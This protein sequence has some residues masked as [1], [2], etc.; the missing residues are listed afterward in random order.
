[1]EYSNQRQPELQYGVFM[2]KIVRIGPYSGNERDQAGTQTIFYQSLTDPPN[3]IRHHFIKSLSTFPYEEL[4]V[5]EI[6]TLVSCRWAKTWQF[7]YA[8]PLNDTKPIV[9]TDLV[10]HLAERFSEHVSVPNA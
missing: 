9:N 1:M 5:G 10:A 3:T 6:Y 8:F 2:Y 4:K 7:L